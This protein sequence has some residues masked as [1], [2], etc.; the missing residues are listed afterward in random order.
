MTSGR[1]GR[2]AE[3][4]RKDFLAET[5]TWEQK[6]K[7][8]LDPFFCFVLFSIFSLFIFP[9][10]GAVHICPCLTRGK[11]CEKEMLPSKLFDLHCL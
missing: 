9:V 2:C 10:A 1:S 3:L 5:I 8:R 4:T 6:D 11:K 7:T